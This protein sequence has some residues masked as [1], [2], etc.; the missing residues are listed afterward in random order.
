M[1]TPTIHLNGTSRGDLH[2]AYM[3]AL[4]AVE[5]T[6]KKMRAAW[7]H[8]RDYY[9]Q[10]EDAIVTARHEWVQHVQHLEDL[11]RNLEHLC[12]VTMPT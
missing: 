5:E 3:D 7:P 1:M 11:K 4:I 9:P 8:G 2:A 10:G 12:L 6:I